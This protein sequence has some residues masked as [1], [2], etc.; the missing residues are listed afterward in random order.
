M[1]QDHLEE[2]Q[3][4]VRMSMDNDY[5]GGEFV[6]GEFYFTEQKQRRAQT[7]D[8]A[9]YGVFDDEYEDDRTK[10]SA[11]SGLGGSMNFVSAGAI[12]D[13]DKEEEEEEKKTEEPEKPPEPP[14]ERKRAARPQRS[15]LDRDF[16]KFE[17][18]T[19]GFG[20]AMLC[21][22]GFNE[23]NQRLGKKGTGIQNPVAAKL[24]PA[25]MGIAYGNFKEVQAVDPRVEE[26]QDKAK[27]AVPVEE[28]VSREEN[29]KKGRQKKQVIYKT[30][31]DIRAADEATR[32]SNLQS[33]I[34]I[35]MRGPTVKMT[36]LDKIGELVV[37]DR[38]VGWTP[39]A[40]SH[41]LPE[42]Q[43]N[44]RLLVDLAKEDIHKIDREVAH[45]KDARTN[46]EHERKR[47]E[48]QYESGKDDISKAEEVLGLITKCNERIKQIASTTKSVQDRLD[49]IADVMELIHT[50]YPRQWRSFEI[51]SVS[52]TLA[53]PMLKALMHGWNPMQELTKVKP[54]RGGVLV[55]TEGG[56]VEDCSV[57]AAFERWRGLLSE[58]LNVYRSLVEDIF[59]GKINTALT[60]EW[61]PRD[62]GL[63]I[64]LLKR[65]KHLV[66]VEMHVK[67][68]TSIIIP[69]LKQ[70]VEQWNPRVDIVPIHSWLHP[71]LELIS[72][73]D[74]Q[75][76]MQV[77]RYKLSYVLQ[78]WDPR[79]ESAF[80]VIQPWHGVFQANDFESL[81]ARS[82]LPK[83]H[84]LFRTKFV[85][86]PQHQVV[87]PFNWV[88]RWHSLMPA[89]V[90]VQL[91][92]L[93]FFPKWFTALHVWLTNSPNFEEVQQWYLGWKQLLPEPLLPERNEHM[94]QILNRALDLMNQAIEDPSGIGTLMKTILNELKSEYV[95]KSA[96]APKIEAPRKA[97]RPSEPDTEMS[98][99]EIIEKFAGMHGMLF[100]PHSKRGYQ[101]GKP[102]YLFGQVSIYLSNQNIYYYDNGKLDW[103]PIALPDLLEKAQRLG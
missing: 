40:S 21:K 58:D 100:M 91:L 78:D 48:K 38:D 65:I 99:T 30:A 42:L 62:Y 92:R 45:A 96:A 69:R 20:Y 87:D 79:D 71:W 93:E 101:D 64:S 86:N 16:G 26:E 95:A 27:T 73:N 17:K 74:M 52:E 55:K 25:Q 9:I 11:R 102:V 66:P 56:G 35:D 81:L 2:N 12:G 61:Q 53:A 1:E 29:W 70:A 51:A 3:E 18:H 10:S 75:P 103:L 80:R 39:T 28:R 19:K 31:D 82:V 60:S 68:I 41:N 13:S 67:L 47:L 33:Q 98:F 23:N 36:S 63:A 22:M 32:T 15:K 57:I 77:I 43:H 83:L 89:R 84:N 72:S 97:M 59:I 4:Y 8:E 34:I 14:P 76:V 24:R 49:T 7:K 46:L 90:L 5:E 6:D 37:Q 94:K 50:E 88:M 54:E 85:V 44:M